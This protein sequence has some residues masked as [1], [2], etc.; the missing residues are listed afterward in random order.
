MCLPSVFYFKN[1]SLRY[2][3]YIFFLLLLLTFWGCAKTQVPTII[4]TTG[5]CNC[6]KCCSWERGSWRWLKLDFWNKYVSAGT[7]QGR[8]YSGLTA[9][10]TSPR[11]PE[12]GLFSTDSV[13]RPWMIPI[14]VILF[15][16]YFLP[17]DGTIAADTAYYPF[18]T[19]MY[20]PGYGW[21]VVE[22]RGGAIKGAT[23]IDLYFNSHQ[24]ALIWGRKKV[25][26]TVEPR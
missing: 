16:W 19:R 12:P 9:S 20:V 13:Y 21:G 3:S 1:V 24:E 23:R 2:L 5:Y 6:S 25:G 10:G 11:E 22:D 14:R 18:G 26:V 15:P 7:G 8:S 17:H 4:E